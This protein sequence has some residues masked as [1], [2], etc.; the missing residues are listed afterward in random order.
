VEE[1]AGK[2]VVLFVE[3]EAFVRMNAVD[4]VEEAGFEVIEAAN[5]DEA[6]LCARGP[7]QHDHSLH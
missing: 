1:A 6:I 3:D 2:Q 5:A 7:P 4:M